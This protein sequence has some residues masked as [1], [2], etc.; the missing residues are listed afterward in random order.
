MSEK[1]EYKHVAVVSQLE[2]AMGHHPHPPHPHLRPRHHH[3]SLVLILR[4]SKGNFEE[5]KIVLIY[6]QSGKSHGP[7][8]PRASVRLCGPIGQI[9]GLGMVGLVGP[10]GLVGSVGQDF[11]YK[12][13]SI[14]QIPEY[15]RAVV[16]GSTLDMAFVR[17]PGLIFVL[18]F[19]E[20]VI[21]VVN[22]I[23]I[24]SRS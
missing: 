19:L 21:I 22:N 1:Y 14:L 6:I 15:E 9:Y 10:V 7:D 2:V 4:P 17:G 18:P 5:V 8:G 3:S 13:S 11:K 12:M 24:I 20:K 23:F 16:F